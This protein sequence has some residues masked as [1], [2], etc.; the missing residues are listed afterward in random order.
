[1]G[2]E[3]RAVGGVWGSGRLQRR[4]RKARLRCAG[5]TCDHRG[6]CSR[7]EKWSGRGARR[8]LLE[9]FQLFP[10]FLEEQIRFALAAADQALDHL[11]RGFVPRFGAYHQQED[12]AV[13]ARVVSPRHKPG[14]IAAGFLRVRTTP[15]RR[16]PPSR[17]GI[18][19]LVL[20][21][22]RLLSPTQTRL[23]CAESLDEY[24][25]M[26]RKLTDEPSLLAGFRAK[27]ERAR[28]ERNRL[29]YPLFDSAW[30]CH[31]IEAACA[32]R[33]TANSF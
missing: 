6:R 30:F 4:C 1:M 28:L 23:L 27:L 12:D 26:A 24:E 9:L 25:A 32:S 29:D 22:G 5:C 31:H 13:L 21:G 17:R 19:A 18:F 20:L 33:L 14:T 11:T 3:S 16:R 15:D 7:L 10:R 8:R 2:R